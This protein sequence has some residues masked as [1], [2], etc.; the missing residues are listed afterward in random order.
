MLDRHALHGLLSAALCPRA[1]ADQFGVSHRTVERVAREPDPGDAD[2]AAERRRRHHP[3]PTQWT[4]AAASSVSSDWAEMG[5]PPGEPRIPRGSRDACVDR[6]PDA[7]A[8]RRCAVERAPT[9]SG[10]ERAGLTYPRAPVQP[11]CTARPASRTRPRSRPPPHVARRSTPPRP[12]SA[13]RAAPRPASSAGG[14]AGRERSTRTPPA[15]SRAATGCRARS[16][17]ATWASRRRR[18][19]RHELPHRRRTPTRSA[20]PARARHPTPRPS[21]GC[22]CAASHDASRHRT[23]GSSAVRIGRLVGRTSGGRGAP[24]RAPAAPQPTRGR[25]DARRPAPRSAPADRLRP[26]RTSRPALCRPTTS[27]HGPTARAASTRRQR[28]RRRTRDAPARDRPARRTAAHREPGVD[29]PPTV[30]GSCS[31]TPCRP[32]VE[33]AY[34]ATTPARRPSGLDE[35]TPAATAGPAARRRPRAR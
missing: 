30:T 17:S 23:G 24:H 34:P 18:T 11:E 26:T 28:G 3:T 7:V 14:R 19:R 8:P 29:A 20:T 35:R 25:L 6:R 2:D 16:G 5:S 33:H 22:P 32:L 4:P 12:R 1:I 21:V 27:S 13:A 9:P 15:R 31:A 10:A